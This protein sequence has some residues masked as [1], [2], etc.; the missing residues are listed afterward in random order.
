M[1]ET[2]VVGVDAATWDVINRLC[3][4]DVLPNIQ[5]LVRGGDSGTLN[6]TRP[7]MTP[8][9]WTSMATGVNPG[10]HGIYDFRKQDPDTYEVTPVEYSD[11]QRPTVWDACNHA[12]QSVGIVNFPVASPAPDVDGFFI[13]GF[14][15]AADDEIVSDPTIRDHLPDDY[16][17]QPGTDPHDNPSG[18]LEEVTSLTECRCDV[19]LSLAEAYDPELLWPVFMGIDWVQHYLWGENINGEPAVE[20]MYRHIDT[21]IGRLLDAVDDETD[22]LLV[23]DHGFT[24]LEGEIHL[25]GLLESLG[26]LKQDEGSGCRRGAATAIAGGLRILDSIPTGIRKSLV[27][28]A[29]EILPK[30]LVKTG[31]IVEGATGQEYLHE[32]LD[33]DGTQSFSFGSMGRV[34]VNR[35][36]RYPLGTVTKDGYEHY[37]A[38][39]RN[40]FLELKHPETGDPVFEAVTPGEEVYHGGQANAAPDLLLTPRDWSYMCYGDFG[41]RWIHD[42]RERIA[43]HHPEGIFIYSGASGETVDVDAID[44]A[45]IVLALQDVP[46]PDDLDGRVPSTIAETPTETTALSVFESKAIRK[47]DPDNDIEDRLEDLGYM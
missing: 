16:R 14:P 17:I 15:A 44:V 10:K 47:R 34:F 46:L 42:P 26:D 29:K 12:G 41:D 4:N 37:R 20:Q 33:W 5:R 8:L 32:R 21:Q 31:E 40:R 3:E 22:V 23:S 30:W 39:L 6:S 43:D 1:V 35:E 36:S 9:A 28:T 2:L 27:G 7:P 11:I 25:N 18:Y 24:P 45:P 38:E 19:T 13:S